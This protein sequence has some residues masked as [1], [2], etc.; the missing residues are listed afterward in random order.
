MAGHIG[1]VERKPQTFHNFEAL[2]LTKDRDDVQN[3]TLP[4]DL[5]LANNNSASS[6]LGQCQKFGYT[7]GAME[8]TQECCES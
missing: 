1:A 8:W 7:A 3:R 2:V 6:C 4:W 5:I